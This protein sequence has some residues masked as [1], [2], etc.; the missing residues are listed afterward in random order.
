MRNTHLGLLRPNHSMIGFATA[1]LF[2]IGD[3]NYALWCCC[4]CFRKIVYKNV[5][6]LWF[7]ASSDSFIFYRGNEESAKPSILK[8]DDFLNDTEEMI[9]S[10]ISAKQNI[11]SKELSME[12]RKTPRTIQR[13]LN[14]RKEYRR[15]KRI[16]MIRRGYWEVLKYS[17]QIKQI[18][19]RIRKWY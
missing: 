2:D 3:R 9:L 11:T 7:T 4:H 12:L 17:H 16:G 1:P 18:K 8:Q 15:I 19:N 6:K 5:N 14:M 13:G 10:L